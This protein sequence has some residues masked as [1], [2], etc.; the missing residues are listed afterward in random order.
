[1]IVVRV[2]L[3]SAVDGSCQ[4]LARMIIANDA[5]GTN[6]HCNYDAYT[7]RGRSKQALDLALRRGS[8]VHSA[9]I[10][11]WPRL[12]MHVWN[13]V[14]GLLLRMGYGERNTIPAALEAADI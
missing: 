14:A 5:M 4:E 6:T 11:K 1:L 2:E 7:L 10:E 3:H 9:R 8:K 12:Q 13:L